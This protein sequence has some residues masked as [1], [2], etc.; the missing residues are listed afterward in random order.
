MWASAAWMTSRRCSVSSAAQSRNDD[1]KPCGT[2]GTRRR[3]S[4]RRCT[5]KRSCSAWGLVSQ[6]R[7]VLFWRDPPGPHAPP[8]TT[9]P[10]RGRRSRVGGI[11][12][13]PGVS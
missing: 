7:S 3:S 8:V 10:G 12:G 13:V 5:F 6:R 2:T 4:S 11:V 1:R 9:A